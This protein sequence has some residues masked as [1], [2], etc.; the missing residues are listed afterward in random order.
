MT[1]DEDLTR[2]DRGVAGL[3]RRPRVANQYGPQLRALRRAVADRRIRPEDAP[4]PVRL[5][6]FESLVKQLQGVAQA[7]RADMEIRLRRLEESEQS[8]KELAEQIDATRKKRTTQ[9]SS[10]QR[11]SKA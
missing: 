1:T 3:L 9:S 10:G 4:D 8:L 6:R 2:I 7:R 5:D 11:T